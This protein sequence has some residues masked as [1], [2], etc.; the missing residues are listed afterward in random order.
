[1]IPTAPVDASLR[2]HGMANELLVVSLGRILADEVR[3][4]AD[5]AHAVIQHIW[6]HLRSQRANDGGLPLLPALDSAGLTAFGD[7]QVRPSPAGVVGVV[8][9]P[10]QVARE[11]ADLLVKLARS[12]RD[13]L[14]G[15]A[16][17]CVAV[18]DRTLTRLA[19]SGRPITAPDALLRALE[20]F[21]PR[22]ASAALAALYAR[23]MRATD[24]GRTTAAARPSAALALGIG[25]PRPVPAAA[26]ATARVQSAGIGLGAQLPRLLFAPVEAPASP[27]TR[28]RARANAVAPTR[29]VSEHPRVT[30][31]ADAAIVRAG[32]TMSTFTPSLPTTG[33]RR[34]LVPAFTGVGLTVVLALGAA[35]FAWRP[36]SA[37]HLG[38]L[39]RSMLARVVPAAGAATPVAP[40][41]ATTTEPGRARQVLRAEATAG[42][43]YAPSF[44]PT[45]HR[46]VFHSGK[47]RPA[48]RE[49]ALDADGDVAG[50]ST[51]RVDAAR[52]NH[53]EVSPDGRLLAFDS[54]VDGT[55]G[56]YVAARDGSNPRRVSGA[57]HA[58]IPSWS[59]DGEWIAFAR[60]EA[61]R[62]QVWNVWTVHVPTGRLERRTTHR[63]GQPWGA[64]WFP[65]GRRIAYN[66]E[67]ALIVRDLGTGRAETFRTPVP[68]RRVRTPAVSPD[69]T[70]IVFQVRDDGAWVL[71]LASRTPSRVLA[72]AS[73][74][75]FAWSP[76]GRRVAYHSLR[77]GE[78]GIWLLD[79]AP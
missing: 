46:L 16:A 55:R 61:G 11:L 32:E 48:L 8:R 59:P 28:V 9:P 7:F 76:D 43:P 62:P 10:H 25:R 27:E 18:A 26:P 69:G 4:E 17:A 31:A 38:A 2:Q 20:A 36:D 64:S 70:R 54:D 13:S 60:A 22:D 49:A 5:E 72:D 57:G 78:W 58:A 3:V 23:W 71:N 53:A 52:S 66:L 68:G 75:E 35:G 42:P 39:G 21:R 56:V 19:P 37:A 12:G 51:V 1:M 79:L 74:E 29:T 77:G 63:V 47:E 41:V 73:A 44:D 45:T 67:D 34:G 6:Q 14:D 50:V 15:P 30:T 40:P 33:R 65:D 24:S